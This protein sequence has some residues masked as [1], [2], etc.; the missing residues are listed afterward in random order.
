[1]SLIT[2]DEDEITAL[3]E[4]DT[5]ESRALVLEIN[6]NKTTLMVIEAV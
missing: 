4:M 1:M 3:L 6:L 2:K 5:N